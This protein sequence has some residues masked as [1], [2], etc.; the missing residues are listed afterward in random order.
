MG[1]FGNLGRLYKMAQSLSIDDK[2]GGWTELGI[3]KSGRKY[4]ST[5]DYLR[6]VADIGSIGTCCRL[7]GNTLASVP[8]EIAD[9]KNET[10]LDGDINK[11]FKFPNSLQSNFQFVTSWVY[12]LLLGGNAII[13]L[14]QTNAWD[15]MKGRPSSLWLLSPDNI[16]IEYENEFEI[17]KYIYEDRGRRID[18]PPERIVHARLPNPMSRFWGLSVIAQDSL[19]FDEMLQAKLF[20]FNMFANGGM[21]RGLLRT[22]GPLDKDA[23]QELSKNWKA[24]HGS[25]EKS[26]GTAILHSGLSYERISLSQTDMAYPELT[27]MTRENIFSLFGV[28]PGIAGVME[29]ANYANMREQKKIFAENTIN[30]LRILFSE[31]M[32]QIVTR[33]YN[34]NWYYW[35][36]AVNKEEQ[37]AIVTRATAL[38]NNGVITRNEARVMLELD[39]LP[40]EFMN[41]PTVNFNLIPVSEVGMG[42]IESGLLP[43]TKGAKNFSHETK[44]A[45]LHRRLLLTTKR[46]K[47]R[48]WP[49][50]EKSIKNYWR[51]Q[52]PRVLSKVE[53]EVGKSVGAY[54]IKMV[55]DL[56]EDT[57]LVKSLVP[58]HTA[59]IM[60]AMQTNAQFSGLDFDNTT[61]N[62]AVRRAIANVSAKITN[63]KRLHG[64]NNTTRDKVT[65]IIAA[66]IKDGKTIN[67]MK[68][69]I[70]EMFSLFTDGAAIDTPR[71]RMIARTEASIGYDAGSREVFDV[72]GYELFGVYGCEDTHEPWDCNK[73]GFTK[74]QID[75]LELHPNHTGTLLPMPDE[76]ERLID[77]LHAA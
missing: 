76:M 10:V 31:M 66:G 58:D 25:T 57:L 45:S 49:R 38:V 19:L 26:G 59:A 69:E 9:T 42:A 36:D 50:F 48:L 40:D 34:A 64:I 17:K 16:S 47:K 14:A 43:P 62:P 70:K 39:E 77:E 28:P 53:S 68:N 56:N 37:D 44:G 2:L 22:D 54:D 8:W 24:A 51:D 3:N 7:I 75:D 12:S 60:I 74:D 35:I 67:T 21:P 32:T 15:Q 30:P 13:Y 27:R 61:Q 46:D 33:F 5:N 72:L 71:A 63:P 73:D 52:L 23:V 4:L 55:F 6:S 29:Y 41:T 20:N 18:I 11:L 1:F 65:D